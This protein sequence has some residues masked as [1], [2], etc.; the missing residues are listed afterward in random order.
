MKESFTLKTTFPVKSSVLY[1]AWL[2]SKEH[3]AMTGGG[4]ATCTNR[5]GDKF[6]AWDGYIMGTN[7][8][9]VRNKEI[10]QAWRTSEFAD[11]DMDSEL[12]IRLRETKD[13]C[14]LVMNHNNIPSGQPDYEQGWIDH[15]FTPM[16]RYFK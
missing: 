13:G 11:S 12:I 7:V 1:K 4:E 10:I 6:S 8:R 9:L 5:E 16:K 2:S 15:Y 14:E 3:S